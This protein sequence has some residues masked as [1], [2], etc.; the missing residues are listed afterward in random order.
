VIVFTIFSI[1]F[2]YFRRRLE[3]SFHQLEQQNSRL[4]QAH[5]HIVRTDLERRKF[6]ADMNHE[7]RTPLN[8]VIGVSQL[9]EESHP[10]QNEQEYRKLLFQLQ[11]SS[12]QILTIINEVLDLT[13][14]Y[15]GKVPLQLK[16]K[17][18]LDL[19]DESIAIVA[20]LLRSKGLTLQVDCEDIR[21]VCDGK[22]IK[23]ILINL[24]SN[25][26]KFTEQGGIRV[27]VTE[28][29][30][31]PFRDPK[32]ESLQI[33]F[34]VRDTGRGV[35]PNMKTRIFEEFQQGASEVDNPFG[36]S[37]LGL[38]ICKK[39]ITLMNGSIW[40]ESNSDATDASGEEQGSTFIFELPLKRAQG[41]E[42]SIKDT[43]ALPLANSSQIES[44]ANLTQRA[45]LIVD[46]Q[47]LNLSITEK[48]IRKNF[49][50][51]VVNTTDQPEQIDAFFLRHPNGILL[52]DLNMGDYPTEEIARRLRTTYPLARIVAYT[53]DTGALERYQQRDPFHQVLIKPF[54]L[55][56][57]AKVITE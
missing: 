51:F 24:L 55:Q 50:E 25:A 9:L 13:K 40:C 33:R 17:S 10:I 6:I 36:G 26:I 38:H 2:C 14:I 35:D 5:A 43:N 54:D 56:R 20:P 11:A 49:P 8:A 47:A 3:L 45:I 21:V 23:Q 31:E 32:L 44:A 1:F 4:E 57:F 18:T 7:L 53:A 30:S 19:V 29:K 41:E 34:S 27:Q 22:K 28:V 12:S 39:L 46:D 42:S 52:L 48:L 37:G 16:A 15:E